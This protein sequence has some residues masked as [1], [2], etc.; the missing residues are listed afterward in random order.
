MHACMHHPYAAAA[1]GPGMC[2]MQFAS[3]HVVIHI[4]DP[5]P[6]WGGTNV[7]PDPTFKRFVPHCHVAATSLSLSPPHPHPQRCASKQVL[8]GGHY[9]LLVLAISYDE[10][11]LNTVKV[12]LQQFCALLFLFGL[13]IQ[14]PDWFSSKAAAAAAAAQAMPYFL[15][16]HHHHHPINT[17]FF[18]PP[19][20]STLSVIMPG[21][22]SV[23]GGEGLGVSSS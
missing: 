3:F 19:W 14:L 11:Q 1:A 16:Q 8:W 18:V 23:T 15:L 21:S 2:G 17:V 7:F 22:S 10:A 12:F 6:C 9:S 4:G 13:M 5:L 20:I